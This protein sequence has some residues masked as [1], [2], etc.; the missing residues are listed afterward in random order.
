MRHTYDLSTL[1]W[2]LTGWQPYNWKLSLSLETGMHVPC[3]IA[4]IPAQVPGS[5]QRALRAAGLLPDWNVQFQSR[6][7][8]WVENRHWSF[9]AVLPAEWADAVGTKILRCAGL[10]YQ[11]VVCVNGREVGTFCGTFVP[12]AF[13]LTAH[14]R[15]GEANRLTLIFT[16]VPEYL[17]AINFSTQ[18]KEWKERFNYIWDWVPRIVQ[19][20]IWDALTLEVQQQAV[21]DS[22]TCYTDYDLA[23]AQGS[24]TLSAALSGISAGARVAVTLTD[25]ESEIYCADFPADAQFARQLTGLPVQPWHPNGNGAQQRYTLAIR[26]LDTDG[27]VLDE[28]TRTVGFKQIRWRA[29]AGAP[30]DAEPWICEVNGSA[31]FLQGVNWTP[32]LPT[33]ADVTRE[34]YRRRL[35]LYQEMGCNILRVWGGAVL[36]RACFYDLCDELGLLVWQEFPLSSSGIDNWPPEDPQVIAEMRE[37]ATSYITRRQHHVSLLLWCGGN[38]LQGSLDGGKVGIGKPI[39]LTHPMMTMLQAAVQQLDPTRKFLATSPTGHRF[40]ADEENF[41]KGLHHD[42]HGP[43]TISGGLEKWFAYWDAEDAL[44]RSETG[45]PGCNSAELIRQYGGEWALPASKHNPWWTYTYGWWIQWED[46]LAEGGDPED[47]EQY[48][49]WSRTRQAVAL[50]YAAQTCKRKFPACGGIIFWMGHDCYPC[51]INTSIVD[52]HGNPKPAVAAVAEVFLGKTAVT[53]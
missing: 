13:D 20:G 40:T 34:D 41:G 5:V 18:I 51:P 2:H 14:L 12:H 7:C 16:G 29:C 39:D 49:A 46:Y 31:T 28:E 3:E 47:L 26:L 22:L 32:I 38:E 15:P 48:V 23:T 50:R 8:E 53:P 24:L 25:G 33:F 10:D 35:R 42:V 30:A 19:I 52:I 21:I 9:E 11:G 36:E 4:P 45:M 37:I 6:Q 17:G 43:W 44:F 1:D 27:A